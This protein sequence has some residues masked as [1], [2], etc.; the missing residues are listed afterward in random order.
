MNRNE[1]LQLED[2]TGKVDEKTFRSI[3]GGLI[4][5]T[6]TRPDLAFSV[7]MVSRFMHSPSKTHQG[8]V[9]RILRYVRGST[10]FGLWYPKSKDVTLSG[11]SDSDWASSLDDHK[12]LSA[13]VFSIGGTAISWSSKQ[14]HIVALSSTEAEYIAA[15]GATCQAI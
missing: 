3:V 8:A 6:H 14:Q 5:L 2:G 11:F 12:S 9:R 7:S 13:Y 4:Y 1:K 10:D 15:T